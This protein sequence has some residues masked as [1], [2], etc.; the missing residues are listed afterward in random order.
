MIA[1]D[2]ETPIPWSPSPDC[3]D[4]LPLSDLL[5]GDLPSTDPI[6]DSESAIKKATPKLSKK[7]QLRKEKMKRT[8]EALRLAKKAHENKAKTA[9]NPGKSR[10]T[11][12]QA[13]SESIN[14]A[15]GG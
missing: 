6:E 11:T 15:P 8:S 12:S 2:S 13:L 4:P 3:E 14:N 10:S 9:T 1:I 7:E 5:E